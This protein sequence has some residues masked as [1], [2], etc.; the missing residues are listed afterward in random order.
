MVEA[1]L[2]RA[3]AY[4]TMFGCLR[5]LSREISRMAVLGTPSSSFSSLIFFRA[6][7]YIRFRTVY[8]QETELLKEGMIWENHLIG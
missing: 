1:S 8:V 2:L 5:P 7:I 4:S 3:G 6:T